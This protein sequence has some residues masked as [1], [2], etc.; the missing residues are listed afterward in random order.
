MLIRYDDDEYEPVHTWHTCLFHQSHPGKTFAGC[1]CSA[2][3]GS[4]RRSP[5]EVLKIKAERQR[6][7]E[8]RILQ[9]AEA[10]KARR[11]TPLPGE[12]Q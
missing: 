8:D 2:S 12:A 7:E 5:E 4:R 1:T 10:I 6:A 3:F 9:E 11:R